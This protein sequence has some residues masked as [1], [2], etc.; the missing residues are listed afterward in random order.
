MKGKFHYMFTSPPY[1]NKEE[2]SLDD[3]QSY[4]KYPKF[5]G[6]VSGFLEPMLKNVYELLEVG[7]ECWINIADVKKGAIRK[8]YEVATDNLYTGKIKKADKDKYYSVVEKEYYP[9]Q[10]ATI[11]AAE[12]VGFKYDGHYK[13]IFGIVVGTRRS[14]KT[15]LTQNEIKAPV[16]CYDYSHGTYASKDEPRGIYE[17]LYK[18]EP[19][20]QFIKE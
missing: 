11:K 10:E 18:F 12:S 2:Y 7:G 8:Y 5:E 14:D 20:F 1:F 6:W 16:A 19:I 13:M 4:L 17:K 15:S 9:I 3:T